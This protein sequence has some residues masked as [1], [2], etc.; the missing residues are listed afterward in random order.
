MFGSNLLRA[1]LRKQRRA[2]IV[3]TRNETC[4]LINLFGTYTRAVL[5]RRT[6]TLCRLALRL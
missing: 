4:N 3:N 1:G 6:L 2:P 5:I